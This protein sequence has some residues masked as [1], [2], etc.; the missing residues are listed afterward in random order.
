MFRANNTQAT[1]EGT[2]EGDID[3]GSSLQQQQQQ[4]LGN[5]FEVKDDMKKRNK[6]STHKIT[7]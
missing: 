1:D 7:L 2:D 3:L 6:K 4:V 5:A